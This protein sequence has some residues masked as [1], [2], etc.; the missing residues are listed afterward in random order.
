MKEFCVLDTFNGD[1]FFEQY[2]VSSD[3][4][5]FCDLYGCKYFSV[6]LTIELCKGS[7]I[8]KGYDLFF[9]HS[10][11]SIVDLSKSKFT[12]LV[13]SSEFKHG[14]DERKLVGLKFKKN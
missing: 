11:C 14:Y 5:S 9:T 1:A 10:R 12:H 3:F 4:L 13:Y 7:T 2:I 8:N 6:P